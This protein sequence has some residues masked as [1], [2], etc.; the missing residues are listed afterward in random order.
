MLLGSI[1]LPEYYS[2]KLTFLGVRFTFFTA[3]PLHTQ[4]DHRV[5]T[6]AS[7]AI[8]AGNDG[9]LQKY[10]KAKIFRQ[11]Q[12]LFPEWATLSIADFEFDD[13]RGFSSFT[14]G[15]RSTIP[16][17]PAAVLYRRLEGKANAILNF[18]T[19]K[20]V[21]LTL[22]AHDIAAHCYY[23]DKTCRIE[24]FYQGRTLQAEDLFEPENLCQIANQLYHFHQLMP[25]SLPQQGFFEMLHVKWGQIAKQVLEQQIAT[26]P[27][28]ERAMCE[29][30][31]EIYSQATFEKVRRCLPDSE[32]TFC[33][34]DTYHGNIFKLNSGEIKLLDFEFSCLN[35]KAYDFSNLFAET[36]MRHQQPDYPYF[37]IAEP[38]YGDHEL[39]MLINFYLDNADF[40]N[41]A[42]RLKEFQKLLHDTKIM[43]MMSDYK[44][45][46]AALPL[47]VDPIQKIRFIPYAHQRFNKFLAAYEQFTRR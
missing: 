18:E 23:Y 24:A 40:D 46:M 41:Q 29:E 13:P 14:L 9:Y 33:H 44:Y 15:I 39:G 45:A 10:L 1:A 43:L 28:Y 30:L 32:L 37:R 21:F 12:K 4:L 38:E 34:N 42:V 8:L 2:F 20:E 19:E 7:R 36:V 26:F 35:N 5:S 47:A 11:C 25:A 31:R 17:Q 3:N 6:N 22:G 27:P 16:A